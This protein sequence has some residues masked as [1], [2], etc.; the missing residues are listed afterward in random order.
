M[1]YMKW[2]GNSKHGRLVVGQRCL[3]IWV[4]GLVHKLQE[5]IQEFGRLRHDVDGCRQRLS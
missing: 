2:D 5:D 1:T 3:C 4:D